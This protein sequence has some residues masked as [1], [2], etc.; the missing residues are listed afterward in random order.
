MDETQLDG[1]GA[2]PV[3]DGVGHQLAD[4][5]LGGEGEFL[6]VSGVQLLICQGTSGAHDGGVAAQ[7]PGGDPV[8]L[9]GPGAGQEQ[10]DVVLR[11]GRR[12]CV[13]GGVT[14]VVQGACSG[15]V[16]GRWRDLR[17]QAAGRYLLIR[18][19]RT[20]RRWIRSFGLVEAARKARLAPSNSGVV[21]IGEAGGVGGLLSGRTPLPTSDPGEVRRRRNPLLPALP[22]RERRPRAYAGAIL[23]ITL[24]EAP[25][26]ISQVRGRRLYRITEL[27]K[28]IEAAWLGRTEAWADDPSA[29]TGAVFVCRYQSRKS[30]TR[31]GGLMVR[32]QTRVDSSRR[33]RCA[34][35]LP[36]ISAGVLP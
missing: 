5:Q 28:R 26:G 1:A 18:P 8:G 13:D 15:R 33:S 3:A 17:L 24:R 2:G 6:Q 34:A 23:P 29:R 19:A 4:H 11:P 12:E 21:R 9:D 27:L 35:S 31:S 32:R 14:H 10:H 7:G 22:H 36:C 20:V 30:S 16:L 25:T